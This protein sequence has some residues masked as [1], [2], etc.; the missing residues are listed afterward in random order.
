MKHLKDRPATSTGSKSL[1]NYGWRLNGYKGL[2]AVIYFLIWIGFIFFLSGINFILLIEL[3]K[4]LFMGKLLL[5]LALAVLGAITIWLIVTAPKL[6]Q[7]S[8]QISLG[9][10]KKQASLKLFF[11]EDGQLMLSLA[12]PISNDMGYRHCVPE[13]NELNPIYIRS[14]QVTNIINVK[15]SAPLLNELIFTLTNQH[16][17]DNVTLLV[18]Q[19]QRQWLNSRIQYW[20]RLGGR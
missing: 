2:Q 1:F 5:F 4:A 12:A 11:N 9:P 6:W 3:L 19:N 17:T 16:G 7:T 18:S 13:P 10:Q 8:I 14:A 20:K 15:A